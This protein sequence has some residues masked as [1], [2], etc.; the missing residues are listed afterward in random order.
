[1]KVSL[2]SLSEGLFFASYSASLQP[3]LLQIVH[4]LRV[5]RSHVKSADVLA[6]EINNIHMGYSSLLVRSEERVFFSPFKRIFPY[7]TVVVTI[8]IL[9]VSVCKIQRELSS[10]RVSHNRAEALGV[11]TIGERENLVSLLASRRCEIGHCS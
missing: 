6:A 10:F 1:M 5:E 7:K 9:Y 8:K 3:A 2:F 11:D 4:E